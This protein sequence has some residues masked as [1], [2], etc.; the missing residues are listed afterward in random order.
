MP[1]WN[2]S[3]PQK[4]IRLGPLHH[5]PAK[6]YA[7]PAAADLPDFAAQKSPFRKCNPKHLPKKA[8]PAHRVSCKRTT[9]SIAI[10]MVST[11]AQA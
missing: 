2:R 3:V 5:S 7:A 11:I 4:A 6:L 9:F 1:D 8:M 10:H